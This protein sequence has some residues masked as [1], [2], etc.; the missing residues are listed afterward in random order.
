MHRLLL[1]ISI[2]SVRVLRYANFVFFLVQYVKSVTRSFFVDNHP[3]G[4]GAYVYDRDGMQTDEIAIGR[5]ERDG[6]AF[7]EVRIPE[8]YSV[9]IVRR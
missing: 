1:Q 3:D 4:V 8:G 7:A 6:Q 2:V 5:I 9:A